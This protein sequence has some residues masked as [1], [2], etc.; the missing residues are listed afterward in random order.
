LDK[1]ETFKTKMVELD[2]EVIKFLFR[3]NNFLKIGDLSKR[4][5]IP[6]STLGSCIGRLEAKALV[7]YEPYHEVEL[8]NEGKELAKEILRHKHLIEIFLY[9]ELDLSK[10]KAHEESEKLNLVFSCE[11]ID[12]ICEKYGHPKKCPCG[13]TILNSRLCYCKQSNF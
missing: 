12:K 3:E 13:E 5:N 2:Y 7:K 11:T 6:H 1:I 8:T 4:M 9:R 10:E